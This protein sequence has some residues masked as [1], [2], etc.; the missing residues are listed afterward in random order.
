MSFYSW[1]KKCILCADQ[2]KLV[3]FLI[4]NTISTNSCGLSKANIVH[5]RTNIEGEQGVIEIE[6]LLGPNAP[7]HDKE[8]V[9][10]NYFFGWD[11]ETG[12][13]YES[14][15][16]MKE[17]IKAIEDEIEKLKKN[18]LKINKEIL[19]SENSDFERRAWGT[20]NIL[21]KI[22][23]HR[24]YVNSLKEN[25]IVGIKYV[26]WMTINSSAFFK[27][28]EN[29]NQLCCRFKGAMWWGLYANDYNNPMQ[30]KFFELLKM[31]NVNPFDEAEDVI[32]QAILQFKTICEYDASFGLNSEIFKDDSVASEVKN[33][34][35]SL[36]VDSSYFT[37]L[38][39]MTEVVVGSNDDGPIYGLF[40]TVRLGYDIRFPYQDSEGNASFNRN[41]FENAVRTLEDK[42]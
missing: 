38:E 30:S 4:N 9:L 28:L 31:A 29:S 11:V 17:R 27:L 37:S 14:E 20:L 35:G 7:S 5:D 1:V 19:E 6:E 8:L 2:T 42:Q 12:E 26:K 10:K 15:V 36:S 41:R 3:L 34:F 24:S 23:A 32:S 16:R 39:N 25:L 33:Q 21:H 13:I 40:R 22:Q 18:Y